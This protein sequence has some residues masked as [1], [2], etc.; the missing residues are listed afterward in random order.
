MQK[1]IGY[2]LIFISILLILSFINGFPSFLNNILKLI[3]L[4]QGKLS[5]YES[6]LLFGSLFVQSLHIFLIYITM[7]Y[8]RKLIKN[9][10]T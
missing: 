4:I 2:I 6:G 1:I 8:G 9:Q 7:K 5:S 3:H 10:T